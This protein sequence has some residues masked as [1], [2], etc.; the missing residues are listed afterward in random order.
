MILTGQGSS[1]YDLQSLLPEEA[2]L[3]PLLGTRGIGLFIPPPAVTLLLPLGLIP[4]SAVPYVWAGL[5]LTA[6]TLA[7]VLLARYF[8]L[9]AKSTLWLIACVCISGPAYESLRIGQLAPIML[10]ALTAALFCLRTGGL[11]PAALALSV[12]LLKPQELLPLL[13]FLLGCKQYRLLAWFCTIAAVYAGL[14]FVAVG[15]QGYAAYLDVA[16]HAQNFNQWMQAELSPTVRGQLL[17]LTEAGSSL[18][19]ICGGAATLG[20]LAYAYLLGSRVRQY[21]DWLAAGLIAVMP[22]ALVTCLHCHDYD[23]LLLVPS[24]LSLICHRLSGRLPGW[25]VLLSFVAMV[26]AVIPFYVYLH[27]QWLL[28]PGVLNP[29]FWSLLLYAVFSACLVWRHHGDFA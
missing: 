7:L 4:A 11:F 15:T 6:L 20:C 12:L 18:P 25:L 26:P 8:Q 10:L 22:L 1:I 29:L 5:L 3:F 27:Y 9:S 28:G 24:F 17:R 16:L 13:V 23:L 21:T 2:A 19:T 14:A